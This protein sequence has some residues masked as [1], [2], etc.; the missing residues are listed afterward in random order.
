M[1]SLIKQ[2]L[3]VY[4]KAFTSV[5]RSCL[6]METAGQRVLMSQMAYNDPRIKVFFLFFF[7]EWMLSLFG[8]NRGCV[9]VVRVRKLHRRS[10]N[11]HSS[12]AARGP[13]SWIH[14]NDVCAKNRV[15]SSSTV[16]QT[17]ANPSG[18]MR[19]GHLA[20]C[21]QVCARSAL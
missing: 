6:L 18:P 17:C 10:T 1:S 21:K 4:P 13:F 14:M 7:Q 2:Y 19:L 9:F 3:D 12:A 5:C 11:K 8:H 15:S 16:S 20:V